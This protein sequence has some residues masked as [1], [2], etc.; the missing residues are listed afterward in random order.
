MEDTTRVVQGD[1]YTIRELPHSPAVLSGPDGV[2]M[3]SAAYLESKNQSDKVVCDHEPIMKGR[4]L[5]V[6]WYDEAQEDIEVYK[7]K[8]CSYVKQMYESSSYWVVVTLILN[9]RT[10]TCSSFQEFD[11]EAQRAA[12]AGWKKMWLKFMKAPIDQ[13]HQILKLY[14]RIPEAPSTVMKLI[15]DWG[16]MGRPTL[17]GTK[18]PVNYVHGRNFLEIQIDTTSQ[19]M[20]NSIASTALG[21]SQDLVVE[22]GLILQSENLEELPEMLFAV[23]SCRRLD[24]N[25][26]T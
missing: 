7:Q 12:P 24:L 22:L 25:R 10:L 1:G 5:T 4:G 21:S 13:K 15:N 14:P 23:F 6:T 9:S 19:V 26:P 16:P 17:V 3:R 20:S 11:K 18:V 2:L 8:D